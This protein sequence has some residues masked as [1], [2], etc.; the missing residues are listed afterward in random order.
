MPTWGDILMEIGAETLRKNPKAYDEVRRKYLKQLQA[1]TGRNLVIYASK[2]SISGGER[3]ANIT[4]ISPEDIHG[5]MEVLHGLQGPALD[6]LIHSPGGSPEATEALV[7]YIRTKFSDVRVIIPH[8][9]M[10]AAT[11]LACS[12]NKILM[13]KHSFIGPIDPQFLMDLETGPRLVPAHAILEQFELAQSQCSNPALLPS[14]LPI[15]KQ[16][17]PALII[18]CKLAISLSQE[19]VHAWLRSYMFAGD[20]EADKKAA[21]LAAC[22]ADHKRFK[23][24]SRFIGREESR[25][26]GLVIEDLET[27]KILQD[28]VLSVYHATAHTFNGT[29]AQKIIENHMGKAYIKAQQILMVQQLPAQA[30]LPPRPTP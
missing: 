10:S 28:L 16:Y 18:Q 21:A 27:D 17:G 12:A 26:L 14:W 7:T 29:G 25:G 9:A 4:M 15:L 20:D 11:M 8:A 22:L 13:G 30:K 6:L 24:H 5:F 2:W 23:S 3:D 19:L 1:H